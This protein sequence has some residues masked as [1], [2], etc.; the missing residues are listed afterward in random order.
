L[1]YRQVEPPYALHRHSNFAPHTGHCSPC[2]VRIGAIHLP[3]QDAELHRRA[4]T[5]VS[6]WH[7]GH[8]TG[9]SSKP[10]LRL[11]TKWC[12]HWESEQTTWKSAVVAAALAL[13]GRGGVSQPLKAEANQTNITPVNP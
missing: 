10:N 11:I 9:K 12:A 2:S 4:E 5:P 1:Y 8:F 13:A 7:C 6:R 3:P